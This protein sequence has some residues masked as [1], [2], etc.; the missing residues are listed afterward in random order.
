M[1]NFQTTTDELKL[2]KF[3]PSKMRDSA[4]VVFIA[5]KFSGK[6]TT[7]ADLLYHKRHLPA[8]FCCSATE[9][10]NEFFSTMIPP[11]Y[12]YK[13]FDTERL[14]KIYNHQAKKIVRYKRPRTAEE[15]KIRPDIQL[16]DRELFEHDPHLFAIIEDCLFNKK[17]FRENIVRELFFN[18]RHRKMFVMITVQQVM[19]IPSEIRGNIDYIFVLAEP[20]PITRRKIFDHVCGC[21]KHFHIFNQI[22]DQCTQDYHCIVIDNGRKSNVISDK[23]FWYKSEIHPPFRAGCARFWEFNK[24]NYAKPQTNTEVEEEMRFGRSKKIM[25][26]KVVPSEEEPIRFDVLPQFNGQSIKVEMEA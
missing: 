26:G 14:A 20:N 6:S 17:P 13:T 16:S 10:S 7:L 18:G 22:M 8:G 19:D 4:V 15:K 3:D 9:D 12:C 2:K 5:P 25:N 24:L 23:V 21:C 11:T 1:R